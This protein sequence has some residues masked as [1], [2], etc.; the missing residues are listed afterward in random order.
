MCIE[1]AKDKQI[2]ADREIKMKAML[3]NASGE[4]AI[5]EAADV[6]LPLV[7]I[8]TYEGLIRAGIKQDQKVLV[9]GGS[10]GVGHVA[11]QLAKHWAPK[12]TQPVVA[13]SNL[14]CSN[15][16][17]PSASTTKLKRRRST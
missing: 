16:W 2:Q 8:T 6:A 3:I 12:S 13:R 17:V 5:F 15:N 11:L 1:T 14:R 7:A 9:H 4:N 10:G